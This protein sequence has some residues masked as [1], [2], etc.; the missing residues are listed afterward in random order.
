MVRINVPVRDPQFHRRK[1][2][3]T[4]NRRLTGVDMI[5]G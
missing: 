1:S 5:F 4:A 3:Y 2:Q